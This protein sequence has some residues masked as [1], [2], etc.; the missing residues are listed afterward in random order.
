MPAP[1]PE[2]RAVLTG[3]HAIPTGGCTPMAAGRILR[4]MPYLHLDIPFTVSDANRAAVTRRLARQ[5]ATVMQTNVQRVTVAFRQLG[6]NAVLR[7][8]SDGAV[9]P[10]LMVQCDVRRGRP[11]QQRE[12]LAEAIA[13]DIDDVLGWPAARTIIEF[14]QHAGDEFWR[15]GG[16]GHDWTAGEAEPS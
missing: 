16:L 7:V 10:V 2:R 4:G 15:E 3:C 13:A 9:Q 8:G 5:Y 1:G 11:A 6:D 14:T 12:R